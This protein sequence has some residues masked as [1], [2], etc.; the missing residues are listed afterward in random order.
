[1]LNFE[2]GYYYISCDYCYG[3]ILEPATTAHVDREDI[4]KDCVYKFEDENE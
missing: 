3:I 4:C 1:M 2:D